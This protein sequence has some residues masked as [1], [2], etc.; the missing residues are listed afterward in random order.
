MPKLPGRVEIYTKSNKLFVIL[1]PLKETLAANMQ[2]QSTL[3]VDSG[4]G[5]MCAQG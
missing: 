1:V 4:D 2:S 5:W 3:Y